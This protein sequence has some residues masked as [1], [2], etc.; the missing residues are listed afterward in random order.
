MVGCCPV[1]ARATGTSAVYTVS[2][3]LDS[4]L[5]RARTL[6]SDIWRPVAT[7]LSRARPGRRTAESVDRLLSSAR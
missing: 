6:R 2:G 4:F 1:A 3:P 7:C 5:D